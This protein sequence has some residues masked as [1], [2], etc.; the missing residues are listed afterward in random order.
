MKQV[1]QVIDEI[2][3]IFLSQGDEQYYGEPVSQFEH[4]AQSAILAEKSG[5]DAEVQIAAFLHD[6]GH[7]LP[8]ASEEELMANYGR[9]DHEGVAADWLRDRGFSEK[10]AVLV[11]NHVNAKRYL[12][13]ANPA[14]YN[15]LSDASKQTLAF[16]GGKME[17][18][19]VEAFEKNPY[20]D[21]IIRM[22]RWDE[23]AKVEHQ[24]LPDLDYFLK[25]CEDYLAHSIN[26]SE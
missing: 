7:L 12:C 26:V 4:A 8:A 19:E 24:Q 20:F 25:I 17:Q 9:K 1:N 2:R 14:Y 15:H 21:L 22:R 6:I 16:Q 5:F 18:V 10:I 3:A 11:E 23:A 13:Y